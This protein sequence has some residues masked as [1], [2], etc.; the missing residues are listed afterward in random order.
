MN[1]L[2]APDIT[3]TYTLFQGQKTYLQTIFKNI[4]CKKIQLISDVQQ[5]PIYFVHTHYLSAG[6]WVYPDIQQLLFISWKYIILASA[7]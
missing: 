7:S 3:T 4:L 6:F 5:A 2:P 1:R